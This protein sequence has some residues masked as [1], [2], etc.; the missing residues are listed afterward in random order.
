MQHITSSCVFSPCRKEFNATTDSRCLQ[1]RKSLKALWLKCAIPHEK[2]A[3][4]RPARW[5][6]K[7]EQAGEFRQLT[8]NT[9]NDSK[10]IED[11]MSTFSCKL[12]QCWGNL[13]KNTEACVHFYRRVNNIIII[14]L[15]SRVSEHTTIGGTSHIV[16]DP[17]PARC[18]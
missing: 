15:Q 16:R 13:S 4:I 9:H 12:V 5:I 10:E 14:T 7:H 18:P 3:F 2:Q 6:Y 11:W 17:A 1:N 8:K